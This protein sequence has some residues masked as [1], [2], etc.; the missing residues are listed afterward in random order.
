MDSLFENP[1]KWRNAAVEIVVSAPLK[2]TEEKLAKILGELSDRS[3]RNF[4]PPDARFVSAPPR[5]RALPCE[6][7]M[8]LVVNGR[9]I[10]AQ[11]DELV[12][13]SGEAGFAE[14]RIV[15]RSIPLRIAP[16]KLPTYSPL[17]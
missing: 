4:A 15:A 11:N 3:L 10:F 5:V 2:M 8:M 6:T 13:V 9:T 1:D 17:E 7:Q 14:P 12:L 16:D